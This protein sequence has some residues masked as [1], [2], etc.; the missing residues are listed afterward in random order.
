MSAAMPEDIE[1]VKMA[2]QE[3]EKIPAANGAPPR[4]RLLTWADVRSHDNKDDM[5]FVIDGLVYDVTHWAKRHPGGAK[6]LRHYAGQ[7]ASE[8]WLSFHND[9][10]LVQKYMKP[11]C[12]GRLDD[13]VPQATDQIKKD[14]R[15]LRETVDKMGL[16]KPSY[17]FFG[18]HLAHIVLL[19][20][21]SYFIISQYGAGWVPVVLASIALAISQTQAGWLQHDFGHLS[22]FKTKWM[23]NLAHQVVIGLLKGASSAWWKNQHYQHH[24][25]P[26][27]IHKDPDIR[28]EAVFVVG[29]V[30]P[31]QVAKKNKNGPPYNLQHLYYMSK[32]YPPYN[33]QHLYYMSKYYPPYNLQHL[34]YMSKYYPPYNLQHLYY[35]SKYY[36]PYNL[37]HLYYMSK[38]YPPY[39]LQHLYYMSKYYPPYNLQH[40]YYMS[41]YYPPY[42]LQHLYYMILTVALVPVYYHIMVYRFIFT[43]QKWHEAVLAVLFPAI[44]VMSFYPHVGLGKTI[45]MYLMMRAIESQWF[46]WA[47]QMSHIPMEIDTDKDKAWVTM[48]MHATCNVE[49]SHFND[50][51]TGH[52]NFQIEHHLFPT[53]P[54]HNLYK[55]TP[56]VKS[57]CQK[58]GLDYTVKS[59]GDAFIDIL[60]SLKK[61]GQL[62]QETHSHTWLHG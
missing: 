55:A 48:Q 4:D 17:T 10:A 45:A 53:M 3:K 38:Y 41:K 12:I 25:K 34:Y 35:M 56:L 1:T 6:I 46:T 47:T 37:Q 42:N 23:D 11:L 30:M 20:V 44:F 60:R 28:V 18:V 54:R 51:F 36:P 7:D 58:H 40:L 52:L 27:V 14:F 57:L 32:Y 43:R 61:S 15:E 26:N 8:A 5:W 24:A 31:V 19:D 49:K 2:P 62:W 33:L 13:G 29:D 21:L 16:F 9:K 22:V 50:W 59:L 39:N